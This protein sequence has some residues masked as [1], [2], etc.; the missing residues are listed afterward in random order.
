MDWVYGVVEQHEGMVHLYSEQGQGTSVKIYL[1]VSERMADEVGPK[2][3]DP[4]HPGVDLIL[5]AEDE[6]LVR[7]VV[8]K[9]LERSGYCV[10]QACNGGEA[11]RFCREHD[12]IA[13]AILDV[14]MPD[15]GGPEAYA[16]IRA[17]RPDLPVIFASGYQDRSRFDNVLP[18]GAV[19]LDK[20]FKVDELLRQ[21][22]NM[23]ASR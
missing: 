22:R 11:L 12:N 1:P 15:L 23:L 8:A 9:M 3:D 20:P 4:K 13:L 10:L 5:L 7:T 2:L 14:V 18:E 17:L 16:H 21:V 6:D 19:L